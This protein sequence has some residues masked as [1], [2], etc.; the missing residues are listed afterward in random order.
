MTVSSPADLATRQLWRTFWGGL[1]LTPL[2]CLVA[3]V[4]LPGKG[5]AEA[6]SQLGRDFL[7]LTGIVWLFAT[8]PALFFC[9]LRLGAM[10]WLCGYY[11]AQPGAR[12]R[13]LVVLGTL[14]LFGA[15]VLASALGLFLFWRT[16]I[17]FR[18]VWGICTVFSLP[19]LLAALGASWHMLRPAAASPAKMPQPG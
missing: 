8:L 11:L 2:L 3:A 15:L 19:W 17:E 14:V 9:W 18:A 7:S 4:L 13:A 1:A 12:R 10:R 6:A 16:A 5:G